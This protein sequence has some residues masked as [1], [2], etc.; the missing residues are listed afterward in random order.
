MCHACFNVSPEDAD[1]SIG[2]SLDGTLHHTRFKDEVMWE[3]EQLNLKL[4]VDYQCHDY[5]RAADAIAAA[6]NADEV[7][8]GVPCGDLFKATK[9]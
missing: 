6:E 8:D 1:K 5:A 3:F 4:F 9:G 2:I 7:Y